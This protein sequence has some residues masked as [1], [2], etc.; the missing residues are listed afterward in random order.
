MLCYKPLE[1][2]AAV[3]GQHGRYL[4]LEQPRTNTWP[5]SSLF[6]FASSIKN[7]TPAGKETLALLFCRAAI[8]PLLRS[9]A[10]VSLSERMLKSRSCT[11]PPCGE[12]EVFFRLVWLVPSRPG[13]LQVTATCCQPERPPAAR[14][15]AATGDSPR[16]HQ[17]EARE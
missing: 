1:S 16:P 17:P 6:A 11:S 9:L 12:Q 3:R 4:N 7:G 5:C 15:S 2:Y 13:S 10:W 14:S 8:K